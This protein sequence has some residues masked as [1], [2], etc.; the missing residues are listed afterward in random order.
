MP[1]RL[2]VQTYLSLDALATR[3]RATTDAVE[4]SHWQI[5]WLLAQGKKTQEV[6]EVTGYSVLWIRTL[7]HR[8]NQTGPTGLADQRHRNPGGVCILSDEQQT[9]LQQALD[10]PPLDGGLWSGPKVAAW[11]FEQ[12]GRQVHPQRGWEYLKRLQFS[13]RVLR[14]RHAKADLAA[15]EAFKKTSPAS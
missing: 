2:L 1:K 7:V 4:R 14:P 8:Y 12:T 13:H 9:R 10:E 3:Y 5:I 6:A 11:I 15:Q